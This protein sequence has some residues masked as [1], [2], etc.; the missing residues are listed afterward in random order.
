MKSSL[1]LAVLT[2]PLLLFAALTPAYAEAPPPLE[3]RVVDAITGLPLVNARVQVLPPGHEVRT[4]EEGHYQFALPVG[5]YSLLV[6]GPMTDQGT[7]ARSLVV[8]QRVEAN[9]SWPTTIHI[10]GLS[11]HRRHP[12]LPRP[13]GLPSTSG[14]IPDDTGPVSLR[15]Y[16]ARR[17]GLD[18]TRLDELKLTMPQN[19]PA[20]VSVGRRFADTCRGHSVTRIDTVP[21]EEYVQGVLIP[22]IGVFRSAESGRESSREVFKAFAVAARTYALYFVIGGNNDGYD[23]DDTACNQR[24][25]EDRDPWVAEIVAETRGQVLIQEGTT[26]VFDKFEYAASCGRR[27]CWPEYAPAG[28]YVSDVGLDQVCVGNWCGHN[29]CAAHQDN[30]NLPGDDRCLVR[31]LC[32]WGSLERSAAGQDYLSI[33]AHYQPNLTIRGMEVEPQGGTLKGFVRTGDDLQSGDAVP[34]ATV[35]LNNGQAVIVGDTGYFEFL[36]LDA[37]PLRMTVSATGYVLETLDVS[38]TAGEDLWQSILLDPVDPGGNNDPPDM[39]PEDMGPADMGNNNPPDLGTPDTGQPDTGRDQGQP[40]EDMGAG[41]NNNTPQPDFGGGE[42]FGTDPD[43]PD[44]N[45]DDTDQGTSSQR[46]SVFAVVPEEGLAEGGCGCS[47]VPT[48]KVRPYGALLT[49]LV[50]GLLWTRRRKNP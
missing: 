14:S 42:D 12:S 39:G 37:G 36:A 13:Y 11:W 8:R 23:L 4:D 27:D 20:T 48:R 17:M 21:L 10:Q 50:L 44:N 5:D 38:I 2:C 28:D 24:Y 26:D 16:W 45:S 15:Q 46:F 19:L 3:G 35:A 18:P 43:V 40:S 33:L 31:G 29:N 25:T 1:L 47:Q 7:P 34:G 22:E 32:Q 49:L 41:G 6:E 9:A 30:P